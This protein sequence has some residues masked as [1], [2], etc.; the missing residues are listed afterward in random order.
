MMS[1]RIHSK[2]LEVFSN[3]FRT[4]WKRISFAV[5]YIWMTANVSPFLDPPGVPDMTVPISLIEN[6]TQIFTCTTEGGYPL[7]NITW[8]LD[9]TDLPPN[10]YTTTSN[11]GRVTSRLTRVLSHEDHEKRLTCEAENILNSEQSEKTLNVQCKSFEQNTSWWPLV[12]CSPLLT[13]WHY[14]CTSDGFMLNLLTLKFV[15]KNEKGR[16]TEITILVKWPIHSTAPPCN[17]GDIIRNIS[18]WCNC[19]IWGTC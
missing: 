7:P 13:L 15:W 8:A 9:N 12:C 18:P 17:Q 14:N 2:I 1:V 10:D 6:S 16:I 3:V 5:L 19:N 4:V 11:E